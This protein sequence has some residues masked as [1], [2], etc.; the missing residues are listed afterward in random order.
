MCMSLYHV[1]YKIKNERAYFCSYE[2]LNYCVSA[3][4]VFIVCLKLC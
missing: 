2:S 4:K 3:L 1:K